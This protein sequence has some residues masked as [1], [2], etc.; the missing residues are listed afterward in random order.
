MQESE[1]CARKADMKFLTKSQ[2]EERKRKKKK[3]SSSEL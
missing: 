1:H 2:E 3:E